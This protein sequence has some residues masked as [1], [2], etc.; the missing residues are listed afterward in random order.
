MHFFAGRE[1]CVQLDGL[2][3]FCVS[4]ASLSKR[5]LEYAAE[6][7]NTA[8]AL[9]LDRLS[10][11][12]Y[13]ILQDNVVYNARLRRLLLSIC[14]PTHLALSMNTLVTLERKIGGIIQTCRNDFNDDTDLYRPRRGTRKEEKKRRKMLQRIGSGYA[15]DST[16]AHPTTGVPI[17][18]LTSKAAVLLARTRRMNINHFSVKATATPGLQV[19]ESACHIFSLMRHKTLLFFP[20]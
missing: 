12:A 6:M 16:R 5:L 11:L 19:I 9:D 10:S 2:T 14:L 17:L 3:K 4:C 8:N 1:K 18:T 13:E 20:F 15:K 7:V